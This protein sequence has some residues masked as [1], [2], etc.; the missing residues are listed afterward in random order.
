MTFDNAALLKYLRMN[1]IS[2]KIKK[3]SYD[4]SDNGYCSDNSSGWGTY[5]EDECYGPRVKRVCRPLLV[6]VGHMR[7]R[8]MNRFTTPNVLAGLRYAFPVVSALREA[9]EKPG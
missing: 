3:R 1:I 7:R 5:S 6:R 8:F 2:A 4:E 9:E